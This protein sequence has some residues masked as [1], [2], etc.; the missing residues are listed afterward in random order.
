VLQSPLPPRNHTPLT[1]RQSGA[2]PFPR[3]WSG[4]RCITSGTST[5]PVRTAASPGTRTSSHFSFQWH[6]GG[7]SVKKG[8]GLDMDLGVPVVLDEELNRL[9][10]ELRHI[11]RP[12][13]WGSLTYFRSHQIFP[14]PLQSI[15]NCH[16][17]RC[18]H[19]C[20][21]QT[22]DCKIELP[23]PSHSSFPPHL[24]WCMSPV[25]YQSPCAKLRFS[26]P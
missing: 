16:E 3:R 10:E 15:H 9:A 2:A 25:M 12:L 5:S 21:K 7:R 20:N 1:T 18:T 24:I 19:I 14:P 26:I 22:V 13:R 8:P 11:P 6:L 23:C 4:R 17:P